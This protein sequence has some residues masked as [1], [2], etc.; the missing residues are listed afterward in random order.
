[1]PPWI[2]I[3]FLSLNNDPEYTKLLKFSSLSNISFSYKDI[4]SMVSSFCFTSEVMKSLISF[5]NPIF[6]PYN[7]KKLFFRKFDFSFFI[8]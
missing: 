4:I 3:I 7:K 1:M 2:V 5:F 6:S 8:S